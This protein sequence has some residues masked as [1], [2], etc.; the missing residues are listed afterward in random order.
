MRRVILVDTSVWIDWFRGNETEQCEELDN[1]L[2]ARAD[3]AVCGPIAMELLQG[4]TSSSEWKRVKSLIDNL[5]WYDTEENFYIKSAAIYNSLRKSGITIR[6]SIDCL[7]AT[8]AIENQLIILH[9]DRDFDK[10]D[11]NSEIE[12]RIP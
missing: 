6:K 2:E 1:L 3:L 5:I 9:S 7:I 8:I 10:I 11:K 12:T 4:V